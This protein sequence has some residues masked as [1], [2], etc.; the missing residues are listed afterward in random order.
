MTPILSSPPTSSG[1][2]GSL[3]EPLLT[4]ARGSPL[5]VLLD[6]VH[7]SDE[8]SRGLLLYLLPKAQS[9]PLRILASCTPPEAGARLRPDPLAALRAR[10]DVDRVSLRRLD[11]GEVQE[12]VH[13]VLP[14]KPIREAE[15]PPPVLQL[16]RDPLARD[17]IAPSR[18]RVSGARGGGRTRR[19]RRGSLARDLGCA[20]APSAEPLSGRGAGVL[21]GRSRHRGGLDEERTVEYFEQF[22]KV[23][24]I[25]ELEDGRFA[26][27]QDATR[28]RLYAKLGPRLLRGYHQKIAE[29]LVASG[30]TDIKAVYSLARTHVLGECCPR[31]LSTTAGRPPMPPNASSRAPPRCTSDWRWRR[32]P[33][34]RPEPRRRRIN[35]V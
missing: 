14:Q 12:F 24:L 22:A 7:W 11:E 6:D 32:S 33:A 13:W 23:G 30:Q 15:S 8:A 4:A 16:A 19:G 31:R 21:A 26:F 27:D 17:A 29:A 34:P 25:H 9:L 3:A 28:D 35:C 2:L 20:S 1:L 10:P 18:R 5:L